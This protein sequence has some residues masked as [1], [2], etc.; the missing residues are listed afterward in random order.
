M[1]TEQEEYDQLA[2]YT[3]AHPEPNFIH[4]N[5]L[6][7]FAAQRATADDKPIKITFALIG[8]YLCIEK[9]QTGRQ[10]QLAHMRLARHRKEWPRFTPPAERGAIRVGDVVATAPGAERDAMIRK[11]CQVG[12]EAWKDANQQ[13]AELCEQEL[14]IKA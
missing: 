10:A 4:Q 12:W 14:D 8:L 1:A 3:L 2:F 7:S 5:A 6:D 11:W 13:I 9:G